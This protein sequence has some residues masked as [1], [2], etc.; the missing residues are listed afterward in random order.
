MGLDLVFVL[1]GFIVKAIG[2]PIRCEDGQ[3]SAVASRSCI[4]TANTLGLLRKVA[5]LM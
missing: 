4:P 3:G 2:N 1:N 5:L